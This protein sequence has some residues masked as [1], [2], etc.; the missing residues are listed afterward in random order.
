MDSWLQ[1]ARCTVAWRL[2]RLEKVET[3]RGLVGCIS[4]LSVRGKIPWRIWLRVAKSSNYLKR[5]EQ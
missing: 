2:Q 3:S 1:F 4:G 5:T